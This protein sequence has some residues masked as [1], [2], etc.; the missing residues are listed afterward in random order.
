ML[1]PGEVN[2]W[3]SDL[4]TDST[5]P[6]PCPACQQQ[7]TALHFVLVLR[8]ALTKPCVKQDEQPYCRPRSKE[9][10]AALLLCSLVQT[11]SSKKRRRRVAIASSSS[12]IGPSCAR[13][14]SARFSSFTCQFC[15]QFRGLRRGSA[16]QG[17]NNNQHLNLHSLIVQWL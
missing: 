2:F 10:C 13:F 12:F 1:E 4:E 11:R 6:R 5:K 9:W 17:V 14:E 3:E 7:K 16:G 8:L 15:G